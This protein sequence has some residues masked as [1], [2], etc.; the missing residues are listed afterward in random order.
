MPVSPYPS[1]RDPTRY[2]TFT[3]AVCFVRSG[4]NRT[5]KTII[6]AILRNAFYGSD[7]LHTGREGFAQ[8]RHKQMPQ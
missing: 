7:L 4:N 2:V 6:E 1:W 3:V 5:V 8:P